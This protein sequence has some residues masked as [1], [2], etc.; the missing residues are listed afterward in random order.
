MAKKKVKKSK[1]KSSSRKAKRTVNKR[2]MNKLTK[3][4]SFERK[5]SLVLRNLILF[6]ILSGLS[7]GLISIFSDE[8]LVNFFWMVSLIS[9]FIAVAFLIVYLIL[10][11]MKLFKK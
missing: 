3:I 10:H 9:G 7:F 11:F 4:V 2:S 6:A 5:N 1:V 8:I